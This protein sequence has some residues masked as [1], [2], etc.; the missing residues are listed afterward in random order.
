MG[1]SATPLF[2]HAARTSTRPAGPTQREGV[3]LNYNFVRAKV[4]SRVP[5]TDAAV[6]DAH[7]TRRRE[8]GIRA[9]S[10]DVSV[11]NITP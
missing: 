10:T 11:L 6:A 5:G 1:Q 7:I 8:L 3:A 2:A 9:V 4:Q